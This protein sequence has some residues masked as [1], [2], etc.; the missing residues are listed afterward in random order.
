[1]YIMQEGK[2]ES[3]SPMTSN[4][5]RQLILDMRKLSRYHVGPILKII[6]TCEP[7]INFSNSSEIEVDLEMLKT[8]TLR[9][10]ETYV[11]S[12]LE[13]IPLLKGQPQNC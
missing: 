6:E 9:E 12:V 5:K 10:L 7:T 8:T 3:L 13:K 11:N 2:Y 1:M 4:E